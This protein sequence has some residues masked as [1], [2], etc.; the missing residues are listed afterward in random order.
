MRDAMVCHLVID[1]HGAGRPVPRAEHTERDARPVHLGKGRLDGLARLRPLAG[2]PPAQRVE[3]W[4]A[5]P[6][7]VRMLHPGIDDHGRRTASEALLKVDYRQSAST[8]AQ[9]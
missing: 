9:A 4:I 7:F 1:D 8:S 2:L 5:D 6:L 3:H